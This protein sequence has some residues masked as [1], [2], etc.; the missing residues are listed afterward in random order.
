MPGL[1]ICRSLDRDIPIPAA[2]AVTVVVRPSCR[3]MPFKLSLFAFKTY[4]CVDCDPSVS[5]LESIGVS[6][7]QVRVDRSPRSQTLH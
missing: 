6:P 4:G 1:M 2:K 7:S 3:P 5:P